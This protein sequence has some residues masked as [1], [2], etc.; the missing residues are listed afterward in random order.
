MSGPAALHRDSRG[1]GERHDAVSAG[2]HWILRAGDEAGDLVFQLPDG[3]AKTLGRA[4]EVDWVVEHPLVSRRHCRLVAHP[5]GRL[6]VEDLESTNGTFVNG[7]RILRERLEPGDR[8]TI[9]RVD[10][11]VTRA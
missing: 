3:A 10:F 6:E 4:G 11:W 5:D 1:P 7:R 8:L 2:G 9:G